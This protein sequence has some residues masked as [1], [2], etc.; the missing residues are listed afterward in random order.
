MAKYVGMAEW[1][2]EDMFLSMS[3]QNYKAPKG[4]QNLMQKYD[5]TALAND[6]FCLHF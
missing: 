5:V 6:L 4:K 3:R 2:N 1:K